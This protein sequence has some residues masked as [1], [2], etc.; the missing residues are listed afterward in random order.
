VKHWLWQ[1]VIGIDQ[2]ANM[3]ITPFSPEAW[4]D[5]TMSSRV[6]RMEQAGKWWGRALRPCID[7]LFFFD[8]QHCYTSFIA[9]RQRAHCPPETR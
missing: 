8:P 4:A 3:L 2:L 1:L 9:E 6:W 7:K 5:E